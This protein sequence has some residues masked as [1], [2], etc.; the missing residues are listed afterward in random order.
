MRELHFC[1]YSR[2]VYRGVIFL[3]LHVV[4]CAKSRMNLGTSSR[5]Q[6]LPD[7]LLKIAT[8]SFQ[9]QLVKAMLARFLCVS[10]NL[11][12]NLHFCLFLETPN[13]LKV[14]RWLARVVLEVEE[15]WVSGGS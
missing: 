4:F 7:H 3:G 10:H 11:L 13:T 14:V 15:E 8:A 9:G 6:E 12:W 5:T 1:N 2:Y